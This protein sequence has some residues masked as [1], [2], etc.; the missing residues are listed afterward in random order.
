MKIVR[1]NRMPWAIF[2]LLTL[3]IFTTVVSWDHMLQPEIKAQ[4][5]VSEIDSDSPYRIAV[6]YFPSQKSKAEGLVYY[7][8]QQKYNVE[9]LPASTLKELAPSRY[10]LSYLFFNNEDFALAIP[11]KKSLEM[12]FKRPI[13][14]YKFSVSQSSPS[15]MIVLTDKP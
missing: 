10:S 9:M 13:S 8:S 3:I 12:V 11:I 1:K 14:A 4:D 7:L 5:Y 15:M 2:L 6:Y